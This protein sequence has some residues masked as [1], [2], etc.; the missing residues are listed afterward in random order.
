MFPKNEEELF[1]ENED[2]M[3]A[4]YS[5]E[6]LAEELQMFKTMT[7]LKTQGKIVVLYNQTYYS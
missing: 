2:D 1:E 6:L 5:E 4:D 3:Y 7:H